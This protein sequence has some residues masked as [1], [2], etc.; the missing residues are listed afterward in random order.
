MYLF[1]VK[2]YTDY[3]GWLKLI[4]RVQNTPYLSVLNSK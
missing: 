2:T 4:D 1:P 3:S